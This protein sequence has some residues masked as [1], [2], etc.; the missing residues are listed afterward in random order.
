M[1]E[2]IYINQDIWWGSENWSEYQY[3]KDQYNEY[4]NN[5]PYNDDCWWTGDSAQNQHHE[6]LYFS[7]DQESDESSFSKKLDQMLYMLNEI[8]I[9]EEDNSKS[10]SAIE[11]QLEHIAEKL[12]EQ[13]SDN[14]SDTTQV[15]EVS[16][17][18]NENVVHNPTPP[19]LE[20]VVEDDVPL[21][22]ND[23]QRMFEIKEAVIE[24]EKSN[25]EFHELEE[26]KVGEGFVEAN[27][28]P[29]PT[30]LKKPEIQLL[31]VIVS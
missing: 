30:I 16:F 17:L 6:S 20:V 3:N 13:P 27:T 29:Y 22:D 4:C 14:I 10:I 28:T 19:K 31:V 11:K 5:D 2:N 12:N 25:E 7:K 26:S 8:F 1:E 21:N 18:C 9:K 24:F 15:N 23:T